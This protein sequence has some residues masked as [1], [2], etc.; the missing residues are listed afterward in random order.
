MWLGSTRGG[1]AL[2]PCCI[3]IIYLIL[4]SGVSSLATQPILIKCIRP[5]VVPTTSCHQIEG[6]L[7][8]Q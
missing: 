4:I 7:K 5:V 8:L 6:S 1:L 3:P 2:L